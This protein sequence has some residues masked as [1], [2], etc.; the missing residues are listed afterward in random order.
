MKVNTS[1]VASGFQNIL[2]DGSSGE[3]QTVDRVILGPKIAEMLLK[4]VGQ[5]RW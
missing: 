2:T 4:S 3:C 1:E 5:H